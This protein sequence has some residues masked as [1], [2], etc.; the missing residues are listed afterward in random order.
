M[1]LTGS[2]T[3]SGFTVGWACRSQWVFEANHCGSHI[4]SSCCEGLEFSPTL[5]PGS[6]FISL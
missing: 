3:G 5:R 2:V 1:T 6:V 4:L